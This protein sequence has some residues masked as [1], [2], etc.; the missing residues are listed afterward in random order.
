[1]RDCKTIFSKYKCQKSLTIALYQRCSR[2]VLFF[3]VIIMSSGVCFLPRNCYA[4]Y[5]AEQSFPVNAGSQIISGPSTTPGETLAIEDPL[6]EKELT[7]PMMENTLFVSMGAIYMNDEYSRGMILMV[8]LEKKLWR[9]FA[10]FARLGR[11]EYEPARAYDGYGEGGRGQGFELGWRLYPILQENKCFY[12][13]A[14]TGSWRLDEYW[15]TNRQTSYASSGRTNSA[16]NHTQFHVGWK[17]GINGG[18]TYINPL[19]QI[20]S[21]KESGSDTVGGTVYTA[22]GIALGRSW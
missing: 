20:G 8:E 13:G 12:L 7:G 14:G 17:F 18:N 10:L 15:N 11:S 3:V 5:V 19:L 22:I 4:G 21:F 16:Y 1:M 6:P 9:R 2:P